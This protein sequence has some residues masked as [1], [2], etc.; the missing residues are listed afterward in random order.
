M[1]CDACG[2]DLVVGMYPFCHGDPTQHTRQA[3]SVIGD[4]IPGGMV[5][6]NLGHEPLT[7]Y[8]KKAIAQEA[9]RR[10]LQ[11]MVRYVPGD[12][13]LT[14]WATGMDPYTLAAATA[15][16]ARR[17]ERS[18]PDLPDEVQCESAAF[19]VNPITGAL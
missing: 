3:A 1:T 5:I 16:V 9:D 12:K 13:H 19:T 4:D 6:E 10:G 7:F 2:I 18:R 8:S 15:L 14:N 11:P 17:A